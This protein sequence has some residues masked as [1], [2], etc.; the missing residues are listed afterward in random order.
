MKAMELKRFPSSKR[1]PPM[2]AKLTGLQ[3]GQYIVQANVREARTQRRRRPE[4][5][6]LESRKET[7]PHAELEADRDV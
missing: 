5:R 1:A 4:A 2:A 6:L 3:P 7:L